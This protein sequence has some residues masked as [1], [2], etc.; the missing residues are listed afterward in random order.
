MSNDK[1]W[2][3]FPS[4]ECVKLVLINSGFDN[5]ASLKLID[6]TQLGRVEKYVN[7]NRWIQDKITCK[8]AELYGRETEFQFFPGHRVVVLD[9]CMKLENKSEAFTIDNPAFSPIIREMILHALSNYQKPSNLHRF[10]TIL[11][12]FA[13]YIY[14][15][16]GKASYDFLCANL[17]IPKTGTIGEIQMS[18]QMSSQQRLTRCY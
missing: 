14:I 12:D 11:I 15:A 3:S 18:S 10:S 17:P 6:D 5:T 16:A 9:W 1:I 2:N 8:H 13:I 7:E 4:C